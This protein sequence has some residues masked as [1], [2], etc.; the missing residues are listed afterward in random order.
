MAKPELK[1]CD[2]MSQNRTDL[3]KIKENLLDLIANVQLMASL[4]SFHRVT[5]YIL[6]MLDH[7]LE[8]HYLIDSISNLLIPQ[9]C[10]IQA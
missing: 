3:E 1:N 5:M 8:C 9:E 6:N 7:Q 4:H 10:Y 2:M